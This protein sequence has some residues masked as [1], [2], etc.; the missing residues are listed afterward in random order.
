VKNEVMLAF[1]EK[2]GGDYD[3]EEAAVLD[4]CNRASAT[5]NGPFK[6]G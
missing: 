3:W 4:D 5:V 2:G 1:G 6:V